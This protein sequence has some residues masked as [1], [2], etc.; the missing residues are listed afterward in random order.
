MTLRLHSKRNRL[1][2]ILF[3]LIAGSLLLIGA[4]NVQ[5][6][7]AEEPLLTLNEQEVTAAEFNW[8]L[9]MNRALTADYFK[10]TYDADYSEK[11]W[12]TD[13]SGEK[14]IHRWIKESQTQLL[15]K[16]ME[17]QLAQE[18]GV[19]SDISYE[20]FL[21]GMEHENQRRSQAAAN[22]EVV[23]GP[24]H[25][26]AQAYYSYY[27]SNLEDATI[28][29][30]RSNGG[31]VISDEQVRL[32]YEAKQAAKYSRPGAIHLEWAS[33]P[34]GPETEYKD[35]Q[36]AME[37]ME[38]LRAAATTAEI[39]S[40]AGIRQQAKELGINVGEVKITSASRRTA[41]LEN[42]KVLLA[43]DQLAPGQISGLFAENAAIHLLYCLSV[44][45]AGVIPFDQVKDA[46]TLHLAQQKFRSMVDDK[47][48]KAV[49]EWNYPMAERLANQAIQ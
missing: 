7:Q 48:S 41:A 39:R 12:S 11:F 35:Q 44:E 21:K 24:L 37:K 34:F 27:M 13:Y 6:P 4:M 33:L 23:Y 29:A 46:I 25:L 26:E 38:L 42:P 31:I 9:Q 18:A 19:V 30:M 8:H 47:L 5:A 15:T 43:A 3:A 20:G 32:E 1:I 45:D 40:D 28:E 17:L 2:T 16:R 10:Q 22:K 14:P 36:E 49:P